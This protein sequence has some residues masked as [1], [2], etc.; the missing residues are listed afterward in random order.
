MKTG[1]GIWALLLIMVGVPAIADLILLPVTSKY[2]IA[3]F[4]IL[5]FLVSGYIKYLPLYI[6]YLTI[7]YTILFLIRKY[8]QR[9]N[10]KEI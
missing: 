2:H 1:K 4:G 8:K 6:A 7:A 10:K 9:S 5:Q 3:P